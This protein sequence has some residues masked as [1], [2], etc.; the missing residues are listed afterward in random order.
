MSQTF[1]AV[2]IEISPD[3]SEIL[4]AELDQHSFDSFEETETGIQAFILEDS[5]DEEVVKNIQQQYEELFE[6]N[7]TVS[8]L[9]KKNWNE[10]WEKNFEQ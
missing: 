4:I 9:E 7:Y 5:F 8:Q 1:L 2:T 10:E 3:F 6:F